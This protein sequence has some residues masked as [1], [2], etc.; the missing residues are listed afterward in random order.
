[1][2][3][4]SH[5]E[6]EFELVKKFVNKINFVNS[7]KFYFVQKNRNINLPSVSDNLLTHFDLLGHS[8]GGLEMRYLNKY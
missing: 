8:L 5:L 1:M 6:S 7:A 3:V 2:A 4:I